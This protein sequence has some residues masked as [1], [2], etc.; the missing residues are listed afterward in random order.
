MLPLAVIWRG[1]VANY[2]ALAQIDAITVCS[3]L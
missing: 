1:F 3:G 2:L